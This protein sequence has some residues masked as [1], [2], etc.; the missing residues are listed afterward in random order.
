MSR[1]RNIAAAAASISETISVTEPLPIDDLENETIEDYKKL[2][3][4]L[5]DVISKI[6]GRKGKKK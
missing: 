1:R 4:K 5:D 2:N 3:D 6:K